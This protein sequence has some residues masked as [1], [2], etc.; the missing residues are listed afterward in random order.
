MADGWY[1]PLPVQI[2]Q[3]E[4]ERGLLLESDEHSLAYAPSRVVPFR[5][6]EELGRWVSVHQLRAV[7]PHCV[8]AHISALEDVRTFIREHAEPGWRELPATGDLPAGWKVLDHVQ[9]TSPASPSLD[10]LRP[11][12][13]RFGTT[14]SFEGGLRIASG[15]YLLGGEPDLWVTVAEGDQASVEINGEPAE[16]GR[17]IVRFRLS[18]MGLTAGDHHIRVG[19]L[20]RRFATFEG[21]PA[22]SPSGTG[23]LGHVLR[24]G[25]EY[26]PDAAGA[27]PLAAGTVAHGFVHVSGASALA[28]TADLPEP[29]EPPILLPTGF[30]QYTVLGRAPGEILETT[31]PGKPEWLGAVGLG[32]QYQFFDQPMPFD[33]QW[34]VLEGLAEVQVRA[35]RRPPGSPAAEVV[36]DAA[37]VMRWCEAITRAGTEARCRPG[38][39]EVLRLYTER[40]NEVVVTRS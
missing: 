25:H 21:F 34:L 19:G 4:L 13:P 15:Q 9:I 26:V 2:R 28:G 17:G 8:L 33:A 31:D 37:S 18:E 38:D 29:V 6:S 27:Q 5:A 20:T 23:S 39:Q 35:I 30:R 40:A 22:P 16:L 1:G 24:C 11:L 14:S 7:E 10:H 32:E 3:R 36:G 12:A